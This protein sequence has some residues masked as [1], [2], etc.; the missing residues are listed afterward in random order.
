MEKNILILLLSIFLCTSLINKAEVQAAYMPQFVGHGPAQQPTS[1]SY[2][3]LNKLTKIAETSQKEE[4]AS[5]V[6]QDLELISSVKTGN[7]DID[8]A[9]SGIGRNLNTINNIVKN[10]E[11]KQQDNLTFA[12][13]VG[14]IALQLGQL[15]S[16]A[17]EANINF[18]DFITEF[19]VALQ[20]AFFKMA[21]EKFFDAL[22][23]SGTTKEEL[24]ITAS[25]ALAPFVISAVKGFFSTKSSSAQT[26]TLGKK[27]Q[28]F[29]NVLQD[30]LSPETEKKLEQALQKLQQSAKQK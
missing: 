12:L 18:Q 13:A 3:T 29:E 4:K 10:P 9:L 11:E 21:Q 23:K 1:I 16:L 25:I 24:L 14:A 30:Q 17:K 27:A 7:R 8:N 22:G 28:N 2:A 15:V 20:N 19:K 5:G 6:L 26:Q